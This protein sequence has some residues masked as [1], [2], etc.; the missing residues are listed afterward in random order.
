MNEEG[1][2]YL[3]PGHHG[4][5]LPCW[6][7]ARRRLSQAAIAEAVLE[8][9]VT[10]PAATLSVAE[11]A[12]RAGVSRATF[13][14]HAASVTGFLQALMA[15]RLREHV[16]AS[17]VGGPVRTLGTL[18]APIVAHLEQHR[19][20]Y[21]TSLTA[22]AARSSLSDGVRLQLYAQLVESPWAM[23]PKPAAIVSATIAQAIYVEL[24]DDCVPSVD[25]VVATLRSTTRVV[26]KMPWL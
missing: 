22:P 9:T 26:N 11:V 6:K 20:I 2:A 14:A 10:R 1:A 15:Q 16:L 23:Q 25:S 19:S 12:E 8:L 21:Q 18:V 24:L 17:D 5:A 3:S 7:D 4:S 13:Y